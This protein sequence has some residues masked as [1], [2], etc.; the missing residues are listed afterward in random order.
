MPGCEDVQKKLAAFENSLNAL[1]S[2][3]L[4]KLLTLFTNLFH[5][6]ALLDYLETLLEQM[7]HASKIVISNCTSLQFDSLAFEDSI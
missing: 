3:L 2:T 4:Q 5:E 1:A 7:F 6:F